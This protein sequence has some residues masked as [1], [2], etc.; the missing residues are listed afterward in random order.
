MTTEEGNG[1]DGD[2]DCSLF[3]VLRPLFCL[4]PTLYY[5]WLVYIVFFSLF[6]FC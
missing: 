3:I 5:I 4:L 6:L 1:V 2:I